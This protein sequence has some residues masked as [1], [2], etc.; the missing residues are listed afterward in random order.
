M[1]EGGCPPSNSSNSKVVVKRNISEPK[2][3]TLQASRLEH[4]STKK[5]HA[6]VLGRAKEKNLLSQ[7]PLLDQQ[8]SRM[9]RDDRP[10]SF[11]RTE[12]ESQAKHFILKL[13]QCEQFGKPLS[14]SSTKWKPKPEQTHCEILQ[15]IRSENI[16][17]RMKPH[18]REDKLHLNR[19]TE[20]QSSLNRYSR[21]VE[22]TYVRKI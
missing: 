6:S 14:V 5:Y 19:V 12:G 15:I 10:S 16:N 4:N 20:I 11:S 18:L 13:L 1:W 7:T 22:Q 9:T 17:T 8:R 21:S 2:Q 3:F